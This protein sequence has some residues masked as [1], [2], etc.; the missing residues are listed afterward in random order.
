MH[1]SGSVTSHMVVLRSNGI[2][3]SLVPLAR[4][5]R[6]AGPAMRTISAPARVRTNL[7]D[8]TILLFI[9]P[10]R[11][12]PLDRARG[13]P[14]PVE[15]SPH[16]PRGDF[17][18]SAGARARRD[19]KRGGNCVGPEPRQVDRV[20]HVEDLHDDLGAPLAGNAEVF[21]GAQVE[22]PETRAIHRRNRRES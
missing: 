17:G 19:A 21:V 13:D 15:G 6:A 3:R 18:L 2:A 12:S 22:A 1:P 4:A 9:I 14:E 20:E 7:P 11:C 10:R 8:I 16:E 5:G